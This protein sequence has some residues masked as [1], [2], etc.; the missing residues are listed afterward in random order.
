MI[1]REECLSRAV[2]KLRDRISSEVKRTHVSQREDERVGVPGTIFPETWDGKVTGNHS[3][4][5]DNVSY[6]K[7]RM[8]CLW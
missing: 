8:T 4:K 5:D 2:S 6:Q 7:F 1:E 3:I